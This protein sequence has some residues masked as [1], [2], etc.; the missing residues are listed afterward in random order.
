M[1][2]H[3]ALILILRPIKVLKFNLAKD[4]MMASVIMLHIVVNVYEGS[5]WGFHGV[6]TPAAY[7]H[8]NYCVCIQIFASLQI[9]G[10]I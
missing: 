9:K 10:F 2:N 8:C 5:L 3:E 1:L 6:S 7:C 4:L